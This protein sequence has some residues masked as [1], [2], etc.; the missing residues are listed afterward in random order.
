[1]SVC[2]LDLCLLCRKIS[3][4]KHGFVCCVDVAFTLQR[5][6]TGNKHV[7]LTL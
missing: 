3:I 5:E 6:E 7:F 4:D 1:M 2:V